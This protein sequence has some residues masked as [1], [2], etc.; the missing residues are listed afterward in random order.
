[1][2]SVIQNLSAAVRL[3]QQGRVAEAEQIYRQILLEEPGQPDALHLLG[4]VAHQTGRSSEA[5]KLIQDALAVRP[6]FADAHSNLG[7]VYRKQGQPR[8]AAESFRRA[9]ESNPVSAD[10]LFNLGGALLDERRPQ[11]AIEC[12]RKTVQ[13]KPRLAEAWNSLGIAHG[14][15]KNLADERSCYEQALEINPSFAAARLNLGLALQKAGKMADAISCFHQALEGNSNFKDAYF[16]LGF[17]LHEQKN[18]DEAAAAY[19]EALALEP[20]SIRALNNLAT[21]LMDQGQNSEAVVVL[22]RA[23]ELAPNS[24]A[25]LYSLGSALKADEQLP[26]A[27]QCYRRAI[28]LKPD[29]VEALNNLGIL[30]SAQQS[31]TEAAACFRRAIDLRPSYGEAHHNLGNALLAQELL[32]ESAACYRQAIALMPNPGPPKFSEST[33]KLLL[34]DFEHGWVEYESRWDNGQIPRRSFAF[35]H[36]EGEP[37]AGRS[38]LLFAEQG[39]GDTLQFVRY[40]ALIK[41]LG[42]T[43]IVECQPALARLLSGHP[44]IDRLIPEGD[45]LPQCDFH[46]AFLSLPRVLK[47]KFETIPAAVPYLF[48]KPELVFQWRT[49]LKE[50]HGFR[51][52]INWHGRAG[53]HTSRRRDIPLALFQSLAQIPGVQLISIQKG[54]GQNEIAAA[55]RGAAVAQDRGQIIELGDFDTLHG[56]FVDTAA[57]MN[58]LDLIITSDT[59]IAHLAGA[60]GLPTWVPLPV[61]PDWRWLLGRSDTPW[62]PTMRLF[63][64]KSLGDWA[65]VFSEVKSAL[66]RHLSAG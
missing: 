26:E 63:R 40:V 10:T 41:Q 19:R 34:G 24:A 65:A 49:R 14:A 11:E 66:L 53:T 46:A 21:V 25:I 39:F 28:E 52:G 55:N 32:D 9:L 57:I 16:A 44:G 61:C 5:I 20:N 50:C 43:V 48:A 38:I 3:H 29:F 31:L 59:S 15:L 42:A 30:L 18:L 6:D 62:Y 37:L 27:E 8:L 12:L 23:N 51:I 36:W 60:L 64:Q 17:A 13:L 45:A 33:R 35:P 22:R 54:G 47:T 7:L 56:P 1:M 58:N 2:S 4:L